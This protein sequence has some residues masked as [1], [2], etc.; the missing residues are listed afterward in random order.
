MPRQRTDDPSEFPWKYFFGSGPDDLKIAKSQCSAE[1]TASVVVKKAVTVI[2]G[3]DRTGTKAEICDKI[4]AQ[5]EIVKKQIDL[6]PTAQRDQKRKEVIDYHK[7]ALMKYFNP[8]LEVPPRPELPYLKEAEPKPRGQRRGSISDDEDEKEVSIENI[9]EAEAIVY[10]RKSFPTLSIS[11]F[12][13]LMV[14]KY[15]E[16]DPE[17]PKTI[18][19]KIFTEN[20]SEGSGGKKSKNV[21]IDKYNNAVE[22]LKKASIESGKKFVPPSPRPKSPEPRPKSPEPRVEPSKKELITIKQ[23][24][25]YIKDKNWESPKTDDKEELFE[26]ILKQIARDVSDITKGYEMKEEEVENLKKELDKQKEKYKRSKQDN[27]NNFDKLNKEKEELKRK[28]DTLQSSYDTESSSTN[29]RIDELNDELN[30]KKTELE[31]IKSQLEQMKSEQEEYS[32]LCFQI[33]DWMKDEK[34]DLKIAIDDLTC[35]T[36]SVCDVDKGK[37]V[38]YAKKPVELLNKRIMGSINSVDNLIEVINKRLKAIEEEKEQLEASKEEE[39]KREEKE[40]KRKEKEEKKKREEEERL[41]EEEE[42]IKRAEK[43]ER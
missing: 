15:P 18:L 20:A 41:R 22:I 25:E 9:I 13:N 17:L 27:Q 24:K 40:R 21:S 33:K 6:V 26:Y 35:P 31:E 8:D 4:V 5:A 36:D 37:C 7:A 14:E 11:V 28:I 2:K 29:K 23:L 43:K 3:G 39:K 34:F 12:R 42:E 16:I 10:F 32:G 1:N 30:A 38:K 19:K